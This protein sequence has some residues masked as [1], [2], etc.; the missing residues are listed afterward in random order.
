[1][2][3]MQVRRRVIYEIRTAIMRFVSNELQR[4]AEDVLS[5]LMKLLRVAVQVNKHQK[6]EELGVPSLPRFIYPSS[7]IPTRFFVT[8]FA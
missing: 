6:E 8:P 3:V 2:T 5:R 7:M 1:M 4:N